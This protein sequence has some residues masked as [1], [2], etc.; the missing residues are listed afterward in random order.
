[1]SKVKPYHYPENPVKMKRSRLLEIKKEYHMEK[2]P[3]M[4]V[5]EWWRRNHGTGYA[6]ELVD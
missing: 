4:E 2:D 3:D 1:M 6:I 5:L